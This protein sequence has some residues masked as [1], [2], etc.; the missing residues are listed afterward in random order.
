MEKGPEFRIIGDASA[1]KK[2]EAKKEI[3]RALFNHYDSMPSEGREQ[4]DKFEYPKSEKE[5]ALIDFANE[6]T[7][8]LMSE[9][10]IEP[11]DISAENYHIIPPE[12]YKKVAGGSGTAETFFMVQGM[13]FDAQHFRDNPVYF[14]AVA[15]HETLHLKAHFS[16]EVEDKGGKVNKT[17]YREG[18]SARASQKDGY[19]GAYHNHFKGLHEAIVS[20]QEKKS[21]YK[22]L[23][24]PLLREEK[25]WLMSG[26]AKD[27]RKKFS[28]KIK[29]PEDDIIWVGKKSE[30][31]YET[32]FYQKQRHVLNY[33]CVEIQKEFPDLYE[34][35]DDVFKEFLKANFTGRL[36]PIAR[37]VDGTFGEGSFRILGNMTAEKE[38]AVLTLETLKKAKT[39]QV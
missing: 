31:D 23:D 29:I 6:E 8:R 20:A 13:I 4:M 28:D 3:E 36:L 37:L 38:S 11:Y 24:L 7:D 27:L 21:L 10:G 25:K 12:L 34:S 18:V 32:I 39:R 5:L 2:D 9:A 30:N 14:G 33:I 26:E 17:P 15:L 22:L 19:S 16:A 1:E 35:T